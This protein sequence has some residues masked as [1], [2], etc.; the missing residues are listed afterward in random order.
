VLNHA[1]IASL[2]PVTST[3]LIQKPSQIPAGTKQWPSI[4][5]KAH[6]DGWTG[7]D[8][9][10]YRLN[11]KEQVLLKDPRNTTESSFMFWFNTKMFC[12]FT[13][14][15]VNKTRIFN[16]LSINQYLRGSLNNDLIKV[17]LQLCY[18]SATVV[19]NKETAICSCIHMPKVSKEH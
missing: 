7:E 17:T 3:Y 16:H 19:Y 12:W 4:K 18:H 10:N 5:T 11:N 6:S 9:Y 13:T 1:D 8:T 14:K 15:I 2:A